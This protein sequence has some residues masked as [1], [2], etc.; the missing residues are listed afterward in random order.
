[1]RLFVPQDNVVFT[2]VFFYFVGNIYF[3]VGIADKNVYFGGN[4]AN[5]IVSINFAYGIDGYFP[6]DVYGCQA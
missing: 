5:V 2:R 4:D 6:T 1:M 3:R